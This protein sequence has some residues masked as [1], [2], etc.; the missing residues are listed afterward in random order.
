MRR[1]NSSPL[2]PVGSL[3]ARQGAAMAHRRRVMRG[4]QGLAALVLVLVTA[5]LGAA[6]HVTNEVTALRR[7]LLKLEAQR[8]VAEAEGASLLAEWNAATAL[9]V[10]RERARNELG[11]P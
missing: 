2:A 4:R 9:P 8:R 6:V 1:C 3:A 11:L 7:H 5:V 10:L